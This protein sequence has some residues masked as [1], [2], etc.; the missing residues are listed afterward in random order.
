MALRS[1]NIYVQISFDR[2]VVRSTSPTPCSSG[3]K[4]D[5]F[6]SVDKIF[7]HQPDIDV[8]ILKQCK[9][10]DSFNYTNKPL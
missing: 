4:S 6:C 5:F 2:T 9:I 7:L 8:R 10:T 1:L 3:L